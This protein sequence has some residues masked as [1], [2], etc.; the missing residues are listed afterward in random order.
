[1]VFSATDVIAANGLYLLERTEDSS[2]PNIS[3]DKKYS[4]ALSDTNES[5]RLFNASCE[6]V[7][8]VMA[9]ENWP[10]GDKD[11]NKTMERNDDLSGWHTYS[12]S[13]PDEISGLWG[14]PKKANSGKVEEKKDIEDDKNEEQQVANGLIISEISLGSS[15]YVELF[16][17]SEEDINLCPSENNCYYLAYFPNTFD[18]EGKPRHDWSNPSDKWPFQEKTINANSYLLLGSNE[19]NGFQLNN[20]TA[21]LALFS[22]NPVY[23]GEEEKTADE[24][25]AYAQS[26]KVDAVGWKDKTDGL[27]PEV[28]EGQS[29]VLSKTGVF[30]RKYLKGKYIDNNDNLRD[31]EMQ[32]GNPES[33]PFYPPEAI[34]DLNVQETENRRNYLVLSWTPS[35]D[36]DTIESDLD[37]EVYY[38][39]NQ[40]IDANNLISI[41]DYVK[42]EIKKK[43][44][45]FLF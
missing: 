4:G 13:L 36:Q 21:S 32:D 31:F 40:E 17:Q 19:F 18:A 28:K 10:A 27:E 42:T 38:S 43:K 14:T 3:L 23:V 33:S 6:L 22:N 5:L 20:S 7:D 2:V 34:S 11:N 1:V 26:F 16:N 35:V 39:L 30:G 37:Y 45:R 9:E 15:E 25:I 44:A 12:L 29:F 8:E 41:N 24:K